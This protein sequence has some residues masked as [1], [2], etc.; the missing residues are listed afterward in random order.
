MLEEQRD[1]LLFAR[2][3]RGFQLEFLETL[4]FADQ[5]GGRTFQHREYL[6]KRRPIEW[7]LQILDKVELDLVVAQLLQRAA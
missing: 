2:V 4:V 5:L 3:V 7:I 1:D 6:L